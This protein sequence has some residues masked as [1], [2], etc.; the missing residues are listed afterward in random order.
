MIASSRASLVSPDPVGLILPRLD[1]VRQ[2]GR[3]WIAK[4][5]AHED[6]NASLSIGAGDDG[7]V[8]LHC[9]A[10]CPAFDVVAAIGLTLADLFPQRIHDESPE[11]RRAARQA[12]KQTGWSAALG[13][14]AREATVVLIAAGMVRTSSLSVEDHERL[15]V[16]VDRIQA[17]REVLS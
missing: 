11:G 16:A 1:G 15:C 6:R 7:R 5:P 3:G 17:A 9:F 4:C 8:L 12:F 2:S 14:L 10:L 13:V